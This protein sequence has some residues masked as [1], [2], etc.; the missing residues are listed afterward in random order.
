VERW[1]KSVAKPPEDN[2]V[3]SGAGHVAL[4]VALHV[5]D[6]HAATRGVADA[7]RPKGQPDWSAHQG[8]KHVTVFDFSSVSRMPMTLT[9]SASA[10]R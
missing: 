1:R 2:A 7:C 9:D 5:W 4:T 8:T 3:S 10:T 6:S